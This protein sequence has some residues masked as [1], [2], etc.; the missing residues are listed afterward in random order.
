MRRN[1]ILNVALTLSLV[2]GAAACGG[3]DDGGGGDTV[4]KGAWVADLCTAIGGWTDELVALGTGIGETLGEDATPEEGR[5]A[6]VGLFDDAITA[7]DDMLD[8][9][10]EAGAPDVEDGEALAADLLDILTKTKDILEEGRESAAD[11]PTG[12]PEAFREAATEVGSSVEESFNA[13]G[14]GFEKLDERYDGIN[15]ESDFEDE[16][17]CAALE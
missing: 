10:E 16:P 11:L 3:D 8:A 12:N 5:D 13:L 9:V 14:E 1:L 7:T 17:A 6:L 2:A 4:E 15:L